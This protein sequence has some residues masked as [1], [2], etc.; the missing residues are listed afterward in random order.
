[1]TDEKTLTIVAVP[2]D[3][4][5][6][7]LLVNARRTQLA[8]RHETVHAEYS[9]VRVDI[10]FTSFQTE[11]QQAVCQFMANGTQKRKN[12]CYS[13]CTS[14]FKL[15]YVRFQFYSFTCYIDGIF[16]SKFPFNPFLAIMPYTKTILKC[17][18]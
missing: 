17:E 3:G 10:K 6:R 4:G 12:V 16:R 15:S 9:I 11:L 18:I 7:G 8:S 1:M 5:K 2:T 13:M 14:Y